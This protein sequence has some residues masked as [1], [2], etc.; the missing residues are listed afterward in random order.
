[1]AVSTS[2]NG[3]GNDPRK[4]Q[5]NDWI[6]QVIE[7]GAVGATFEIKNLA[8][9]T[10]RALMREFEAL[11]G[12]IDKTQAAMRELSVPPG[13]NRSLGVTE[14]RMTAI[15]NAAK[16]A[17]DESAAAFVKVDESAAATVASLGRVAAAMKG[18]GAEARA[19]N[20]SS[21]PMGA[22]GHGGGRGGMF[23]T[24]GPA[25]SLPGGTH[26][27]ASSGG[28]GFWAVVASY[29][30]ADV[31]KNVLEQGGHLE[32]EKKLLSDKLGS[33]GTD[34]DIQGATSAAVRYATGGPDSIIGTTPA[35]NLKG[36]RELMS[37]TPTLADAEALYGPMMRVSK[38]L[39]ELSG[40]AKKADETMP[41]LAKALENLG[42]GIDP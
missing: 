42:G 7:A 21:L 17:G 5:I 20:G 37:V 18:V 2:I 39:E 14:T 34:A 41:V 33:R 40:G 15:A 13:M 31:V 32:T 25:A 30:G 36:I 27:T 8:S 38:A 12:A 1:V 19:V 16:V 28:D 3:A 29:V 11:Q 9:A 10:L 6:F 4:A 23:H 26:V 24:R 35:E 22:G